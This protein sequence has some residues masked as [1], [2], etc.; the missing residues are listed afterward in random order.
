MVESAT[1]NYGWIKPEVQHSPS[2]WGG[3]INNNFDA[4]DA[5]VFANQQAAAPVGG[6]ALW[7][8]ATAPA[9]WLICD[10]SSLDTTAYA[11][12]FAVVGYAFG[13][14]GPNF[15]L[16][17]FK[18][19]FPIGT[20]ATR[21]LAAKGGAA[22]VTLDATMIPAHT[23]TATQ[24][25]HTHTASQ[26]AHTHPDPT[27]SHTTSASQDAHTHAGVVTGLQGGLPGGPIAGGAGGNLISGSTG[28]ASANGVYVTVNPAATNLQ[29]A[30]NDPVTVVANSAGAITVAANTGG[31]KAHDNMPPWLGVNFIIRFQ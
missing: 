17:N 7:F 13:G 16:P 21:A 25:T 29:A 22:T 19:I 12:L 28:G 18:D 14:S 10:G 23:H 31:G 6:G 1:K 2:T 27:H 24:P 11:L 30:G 5:L 26:P 9:N 4:I 3:F 20:S 8:T 15:N